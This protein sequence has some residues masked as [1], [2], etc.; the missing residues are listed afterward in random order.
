MQF[1]P[2]IIFYI[3]KNLQDV[4]KGVA[5]FQA[6]FGQWWPL[7]L[8]RAQRAF[9][10]KADI[11]SFSIADFAL[12]SKFYLSITARPSYLSPVVWFTCSQEEVTFTFF[13]NN[14]TMQ[15]T[16]VI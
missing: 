2:K 11:A 14:K 7:I 9:F 4:S 10:F 12:V 3:I 16:F 13:V 1:L 5:I 6:P 8:C 15:I